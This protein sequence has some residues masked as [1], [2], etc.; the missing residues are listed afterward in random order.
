MS[1]NLQNVTLSDGCV[2]KVTLLGDEPGKPLLIAN[3]G[4]PGMSTYKETEAALACFADIFRV[5]L[6]D[7]RGS[8][9]SDRKG[10][11]SHARWAQDVDDLRQWAGAEKMIMTGASHGGFITLEYALVYHHHLHAIIIGDS[12]A[13]MAH[14]AAF[15]MMKTALTDPRCQADPEQLLRMFSG[16]A[17]S[18]EDLLTG[19]ATVAPLFAAPAELKAQSEVDLDAIMPTMLAPHYETA[20]AAM[21]DCL[22]RYDLRDRLH[23]IRVPTLVYVGRY[24]WI[25]P[26]SSSEEIVAKIPGA[27]LI[28][29]EK[30]GHFAALEEK[31]R[32]QR[33]FR[34]FVKGLGIEG[35][36]A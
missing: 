21:G 12:A 22:S 8:G 33:D 15:N 10:P 5:L 3:H 19:F 11:Y 29:Y 34:D 16:R 9:Q 23:E 27:K 28:I 31:T 36:K 7:M 17:T 32:F 26:V 25:T 35:V 13:Q 4:S 1:S 24:D 14:W 20:N 6:F 2:L 30:S 18:Q